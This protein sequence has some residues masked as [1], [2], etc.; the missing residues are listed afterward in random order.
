MSIIKEIYDVAKDGAALKNKASGIKKA[1]RTELKLNR[2]CLLDIEEGINLENDRRIEI[3][4]MLDIQELSAAVKY[5]IPYSTISRKMVTREIATE[6]K[7]KRIEGTNIEKLIEDLYLL[8]SY[9]KKDYR[10]KRISLNLRLINIYK[11][12]RVLIELLK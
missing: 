8:I 3:I 2:K 7:V 5:E 12:N 9:L 4:K 6:F 1:L 11:Y 10:N